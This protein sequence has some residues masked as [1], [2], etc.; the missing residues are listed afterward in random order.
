MSEL[1][2]YF[3]TRFYNDETFPTPLVEV[4][5]ADYTGL[6]VLDTGTTPTR[7]YSSVFNDKYKEGMYS[8]RLDFNRGGQT[9]SFKISKS[10]ASMKMEVNGK[11]MMGILSPQTLGGKNSFILIDFMH[12]DVSGI[13][14]DYKTVKKGISSYFNKE[15]KKMNASVQYC[16]LQP[17]ELKD[18]GPATIFVVE[19]GFNNQAKA[20]FLLDTG[21]FITQVFQKNI[22]ECEIISS[23][24][25]ASAHG[26]YKNELIKNIPMKMGDIE[27]TLDD[28]HIADPKMELRLNKDF[29][30]KDGRSIQG[31]LGINSFMQKNNRSFLLL[32]CKGNAGPI[33]FGVIKR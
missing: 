2:Y 12:K 29:K 10:P 4:S 13:L 18:R 17:L 24:N 30:L 7:I 14:G 31:L 8:Y 32:P 16:E 26:S 5:I 11:K 1:Q 20:P 22:G 25:V 21:A 27:I 9:A 6:M 19:A 23:V 15:V 33:F 28:M 3:I